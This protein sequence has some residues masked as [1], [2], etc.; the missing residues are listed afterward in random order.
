MIRSED[1]KVGSGGNF[2]YNLSVSTY[3]RR[4]VIYSDDVVATAAFNSNSNYER[5]ATLAL[6]EAAHT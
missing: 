4:E 2:F 1:W 3:G 6:N 5:A